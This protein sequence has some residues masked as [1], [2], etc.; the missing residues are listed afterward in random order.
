MD[1]QTILIQFITAFTGC[2]GFSIVFHVRKSQWAAASTGGVLSWAVYLAAAHASGDYA[3]AFAGACAAALYGEVM[4]HR[5]HAPSTI[6]TV[7]ASI[8]LVPGASLYRSADSMMNGSPDAGRQLGIYTLVFAACMSAGI[9]V[10]TLIFR[11]V[12][13][14]IREKKQKQ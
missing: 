3:G 13:K 1:I 14:K 5:E 4:A 11:A 9:V 10:T 7:I 2:L 12:S 6:F 8:P